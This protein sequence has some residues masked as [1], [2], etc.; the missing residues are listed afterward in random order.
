MWLSAQHGPRRPTAP[1]CCKSFCLPKDLSKHE[2]YYRD[3]FP[4]YFVLGALWHEPPR[5]ELLF[6]LKESDLY[7]P[8][9][10]C[11]ASPP[12]QPQYI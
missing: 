12:S 6:R 7:I 4:E 11:P 3:R 5:L 10:P 2:S 8:S 1:R 9:Y